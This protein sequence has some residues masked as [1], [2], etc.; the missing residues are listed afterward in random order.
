MRPVPLPKF[1]RKPVDRF[2]YGSHFKSDLVFAMTKYGLGRF[3]SQA[4]AQS[5][6]NCTL[7]PSLGPPCCWEYIVDMFKPP[8]MKEW[9][10]PGGL[11]RNS[12]TLEFAWGLNLEP[13]EFMKQLSDNGNLSCR[14]VGTP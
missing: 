2:L 10:I 7:S 5:L 8:L 4:S 9:D 12:M 11:V 14:V 1:R 13:S 3:R 6:R